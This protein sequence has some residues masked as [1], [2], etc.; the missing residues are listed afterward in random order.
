MPGTW[1]TTPELEPGLRGAGAAGRPRGR[2][3]FAAAA[4]RDLQL[5]VFALGT[6]ELA[7]GQEGPPVGRT[8][9][10]LRGRPAVQAA[11]FV[12]ILID[13]QKLGGEEK[14]EETQTAVRT[15][16]AERQ[17]T[18]APGASARG[19]GAPLLPE[20]SRKVDSGT[21]LL[22]GMGWG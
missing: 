4:V 9:G 2:L 17:D 10:L 1:D 6:L 15:H 13:S 7:A 14:R 12:L 21:L 20:R 8:Q 5:R 3:T 19:G 18:R 16:S 11:V 22:W